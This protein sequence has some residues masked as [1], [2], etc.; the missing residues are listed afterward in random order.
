VNSIR[1]D[2]VNHNLLF[3]PT[4]FGF[5]VSLDD[6]QTWKPFMTGLPAGRVDDVLV[7]PREHDLILA[8]HSRSLWIM[9]D[10]TPLEQVSVPQ[11]QDVTLL[12]P[13]NAVLWKT[14]RMNVTEVPGDRYWEADPAP[15]GTAISY[16]LK[17]A[18]TEARIVITDTA[19]GQPALAC[20]AD[21]SFGLRAGL[22]RFQWPL[23]TDQQVAAAN[24]GLSGSG[25]G[26]PPS[27]GGAVNPVPCAT[28][29]AASGR[30][31][32]VGRGGGPPIHPGVYRVTLTVNGK[33]A[34]SQT[35]DVLEDVWL[36]EK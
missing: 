14:D 33:D 32:F 24:R 36:T 18:A 27:A 4:E 10:I 15:R 26:T 20:V 34:G 7:H 31:V 5:Y 22:N 2:P 11:A 3:A 16:V 25:R 19:T 12:R 17:A 8:T 13:R 29:G 6:G 35:F 28:V 1:Q 9:D 23:V 21:A 30:G